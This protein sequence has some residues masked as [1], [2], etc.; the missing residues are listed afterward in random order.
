[1]KTNPFTHTLNPEDKLQDSILGGA[2]GED[3]SSGTV[4]TGSLASKSTATPSDNFEPTWRARTQDQVLTI[5]LDAE[6][7][8]NS[9]AAQLKKREVKAK[10]KQQKSRDGLAQ[11]HA[12]AVQ[13]KFDELYKA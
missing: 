11:M 2:N 9:Q 5:D 12:V 4:P 3:T 8:R 10:E 1:M 7:P 6:S 13:N